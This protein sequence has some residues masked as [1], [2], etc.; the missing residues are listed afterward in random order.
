MVKDHRT[1]VQ[2]GDTDRVLDG[3]IQPFIDG[4]LK[5]ELIAESDSDDEPF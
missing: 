5:G 4:F 2:E 1:G 3:G